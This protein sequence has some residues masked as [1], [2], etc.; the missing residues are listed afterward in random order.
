MPAFYPILILILRES[1]E[2]KRYHILEVFELASVC[3]MSCP[4]LPCVGVP[5]FFALIVHLVI[6]VFQRA[7]V[8]V[9]QCPR[10]M[11]D[12]ILRRKV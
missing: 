12:E 6:Y 9:T 3:K 7:A 5:Q 1:I 2:Y 4:V 8:E 10:T 11:M